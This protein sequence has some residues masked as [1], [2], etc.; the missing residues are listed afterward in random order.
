MKGRFPIL[1][2]VV[3]CFLLVVPVQHLKTVAAATSPSSIQRLQITQSSDGPVV[4]DLFER[5]GPPT[6]AGCGTAS[7]YPGSNNP[8]SC[9]PASKDTHYYCPNCAG[10]LSVPRLP[11]TQIAS[12]PVPSCTRRVAQR[13]QL[14][15]SAKSEPMRCKLS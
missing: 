2:F 4:H 6:T 15:A 12:V 1:P 13:A 11:T 14:T 7:C 8:T 10:D 9:E 5:F 3:A